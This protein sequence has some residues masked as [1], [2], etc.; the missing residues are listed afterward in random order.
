MVVLQ[1]LTYFST[2]LFVQLRKIVNSKRCI[3][4]SSVSFYIRLAHCKCYTAL[5][6]CNI[7]KSRLWVLQRD[8]LWRLGTIKLCIDVN[9][10][11]YC[12]VCYLACKGA[13]NATWFSIMT[14]KALFSNDRTE[15]YNKCTAPVAL[16]L[17][18]V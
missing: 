16:K 11:L 10:E 18:F 3:F 7:L 14:N 4:I 1:N 8:S 15:T 9:I 5:Y 12:K 6:I 13:L 17:P 2:K